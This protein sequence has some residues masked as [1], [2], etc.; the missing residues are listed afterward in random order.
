MS[1]FVLKKP[2]IIFNPKLINFSLSHAQAQPLLRISTSSSTSCAA[3][4]RVWRFEVLGSGFGAFCSES[5]FF[6]ALVHPV[7]VLNVGILLEK[8]LHVL[9]TY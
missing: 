3:G 7:N 5:K 9:S 2:R 6:N 1:P 4:F 8:R